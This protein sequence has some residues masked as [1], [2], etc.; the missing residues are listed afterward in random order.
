MVAASISEKGSDGPIR[1]IYSVRGCEEE[2]EGPGHAFLQPGPRLYTE[3]G[4]SCSVFKG[5]KQNTHGAV[6]SLL[7]ADGRRWDADSRQPG[8]GV[9]A[10]WVLRGWECGR[11]RRKWYDAYWRWKRHV[12]G[13][14]AEQALLQ[15]EIRWSLPAGH[16]ES[17]AQRR[18]RGCVRQAEYGGAIDAS[19]HKH[20]QPVDGAARTCPECIPR[21]S[22]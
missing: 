11:C 8:L 20:P 12:R 1:S 9:S 13:Q 18:R 2:V 22:L 19:E 15:S 17:V 6:E 5:R 10:C 16:A 7:L 21:G 14:R 3:L 4:S